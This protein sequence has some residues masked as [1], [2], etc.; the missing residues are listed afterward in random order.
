MVKPERFTSK[1]SDTARHIKIPRY[2]KGNKVEQKYQCTASRQEYAAQCGLMF[3]KN[4]ISQWAS[5]A[6]G[7]SHFSRP[8]LAIGPVF[9]KIIEKY[10]KSL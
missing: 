7:F 10:L 3:A 1:S 5:A 2:E 6:L 9:K 4:I 8:P